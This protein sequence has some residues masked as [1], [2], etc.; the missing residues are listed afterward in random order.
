MK[1]NIELLET[2]LKE[3]SVII[4]NTGVDLRHDPDTG[5]NGVVVNARKKQIEMIED[6]A[7]V[8]G[9]TLTKKE[10]PV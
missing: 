5:P 10:L 3:C 2:A 8:F 6:L 1:K 4:H 7:L 9:K